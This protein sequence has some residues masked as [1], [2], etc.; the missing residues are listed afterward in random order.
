M[1]TEQKVECQVSFLRDGAGDSSLEIKG[2][3]VHLFQHEYDSK[4]V[5]WYGVT[6][7]SISDNEFGA[8]LQIPHHSRRIRFFLPDARHGT[9]IMLNA[10]QR[11]LVYRLSFIG[12]TQLCAD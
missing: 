11:G 5:F 10:E 4:T 12:I 1:L 8:I 7:L 3:L 9:A 6:E 2:A